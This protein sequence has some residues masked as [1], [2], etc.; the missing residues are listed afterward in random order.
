MVRHLKGKEVVYTSYTQTRLL[1]W[2]WMGRYPI[3]YS[4]LYD[5]ILLGK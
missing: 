5:I 4:R 1:Q 2:Y 3:A